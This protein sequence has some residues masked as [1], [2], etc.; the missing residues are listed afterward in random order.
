MYLC[1]GNHDWSAADFQLITAEIY[2]EESSW[3]AARS[4]IGPGVQ[5]GRGA[6]LGLGSVT[7]RSLEAMTIYAGN[8][9]LPIKKREIFEHKS[10]ERV[11]TPK[12]K[13]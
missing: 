2:I 11:A 8:P 12:P 7:G 10:S 1:T 6:I 5:V 13:N 3:I 4:V 9:A